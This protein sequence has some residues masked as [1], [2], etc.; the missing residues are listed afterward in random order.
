MDDQRRNMA[1]HTPSGYAFLQAKYDWDKK[2]QKQ[3]EIIL[4]PW[5][6]I[7]PHDTQAKI[8][9]NQDLVKLQS[10][11]GVSC[12]EALAILDDRKWKAIETYEAYNELKRRVEAYISQADNDQSHE[13]K[14]YS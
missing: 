8:N 11:G 7:A 14:A 1:E 9:H 3:F 6:M 13:P 2:N 5:A 10:R 4:I 12:C